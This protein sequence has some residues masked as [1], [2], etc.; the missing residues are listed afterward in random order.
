[1]WFKHW[2]PGF[3][4]SYPNF[5]SHLVAQKVRLVRR[6]LPY[7]FQISWPAHN[8]EHNCQNNKTTPLI[9]DEKQ[10]LVLAPHHIFHPSMQ[11]D[12]R[13]RTPFLFLLRPTRCRSIVFPESDADP[14]NFFTGTMFPTAVPGD[15][16]GAQVH[17]WSYMATRHEL[18]NN[19][20]KKFVKILPLGKNL[21][22][23]SLFISSILWLSI[24]AM[25]HKHFGNLLFP[26]AL[27]CTLCNE[28]NLWY[29]STWG[30]VGCNCTFYQRNDTRIFSIH[31]FK[32]NG[33]NLSLEQ[34]HQN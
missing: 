10:T 18:R 9:V 23:P 21:K 3:F 16:P 29:E 4:L 25:Q 8:T 22:R 17:T 34:V 32:H 14:R 11:K 19:P 27:K 12:S 31:P 6:S 24:S 5:W 15:F 28:C 13:D 30:I 20:E 26:W 1:M 7:L 33:G 2:T